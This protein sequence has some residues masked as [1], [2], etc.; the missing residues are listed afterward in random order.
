LP[1]YAFNRSGSP[2]GD[3]RRRLGGPCNI[4]IILLTLCEC[5]PER[6]P[7]LVEYLKATRQLPRPYPRF[8]SYL[9]KV[10][11]TI[12]PLDTSWYTIWA[13][14]I[15]IVAT[16]RRVVTKVPVPGATALWYSTLSFVLCC[17]GRNF[18]NI[19]TPVPSAFLALL[20][21]VSHPPPPLPNVWIGLHPTARG[22]TPTIRPLFPSDVLG[23]G[24]LV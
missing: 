3:H 13:K 2:P 19:V 9:Y 21:S 4:P 12:P 11:E 10:Y 14:V 18:R 5:S 8:I 6:L 17:Y 22:S 23:L 7:C 1:S 16:Y 24:A 15:V 20:V